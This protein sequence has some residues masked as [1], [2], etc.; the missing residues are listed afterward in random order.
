MNRDVCHS[1]PA[2]SAFEEQRQ[3]C[4][5]ASSGTQAS[6]CRK[7]FTL[8]EVMLSVILVSFVLT[9]VAMA[10]DIHLRALDSGRAKIEEGQL[11]RAILQRIADD[12]RNMVV[13]RPADVSGQ[14]AGANVG[15]GEGTDEATGEA[16]T[17]DFQSDESSTGL[18]VAG[19][20]PGVYGESDWLQIDVMRLPRIDEY[21]DDTGDTGE[22]DVSATGDMLSAVKTVLYFLEVPEESGAL[23]ADGSARYD[24]GLTRREMD[25]SVT[26]WADRQGTLSQM[27][28]DL[29]PLAV[30][31]SDLSF[32]YYDGIEF[33]DHWDTEE[34]NGLPKAVLISIAVAPTDD[35]GGEFATLWSSV[36]SDL[37]REG[38]TAVY[39]LL[40]TLPISEAFETGGRT[41]GES[42][43][44]SPGGSS[45]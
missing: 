45:P 2:S 4:L 26:L 29:E 39:R 27:N 11:A 24:G 37:E 44:A 15:T 16:T 34:E 38:E 8:L 1:L 5:Q 32:G 42:N 14:Q 3:D 22:T 17:T 21:E 23:E 40:V 35:A 41:N 20:I 6:G 18:G 25:R 30:E 13:Y 9:I 33:L 28:L 43:E 7:A 12:L 19:S 36:G 10:I 31:V